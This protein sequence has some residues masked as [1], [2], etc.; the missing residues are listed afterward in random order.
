[1]K[2]IA[3][4]TEQ[5]LL[6]SALYEDESQF[7]AIYGRRRV[8]K[9]FLIRETYKGRFLFEHAG[10]A[11]G[12]KT[13]QL[14]S[15]AAS[16]RRSGLKNARIPDNWLDAFEMLKD[17][18]EQ[19]KSEKK[20]LFIDELS[21]MDT[22]KSGLITAIENFWNSWASGRNDVVFIICASATSW[23]MD[24]VIHNK[25]GLYNRLTLQIHLKPF[26]LYECEEYLKS[27]NII[28]NRYEIL[29]MYMIIG[30]I[31]FYWKMIKKGKSLAQNVDAMFFA[32]NAPLQDEFKY[33]YASLFK[34]P[35][36]YLSIVIAL[37]SKKAGMTRAELAKKTGIPD[38]GY[39]TKLTDELINCGFIRKYS[40][41]GKI[42]KD[43]VYQLID[44]YTLFYFHF[45]E[46]LPED[47]N[48]WMNHIDTPTRNAWCGVAFERV[49]MEHISQIKT[50]LG[51]KGVLSEVHA[52]SCSGN[53]LE[54]YNGAQ[55]DL[56]IVRKDQVINICEMKYSKDEYTFSGKDDESMRNKIRAFKIV[57]KTKY[58]IHP[59]LVTTY[60]LTGGMYSG[61]IQSVITADD[62]FAR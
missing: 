30:G 9:T 6:K 55:I 52:W 25:G 62:L 61:R 10:L 31:P 32:E 3:R 35:K 27:R 51:I 1:M 34:K 43:A 33:L 29:E 47:E 22:P 23:M 59:T 50:A 21:W 46:K 60:G 40:M 26:S 8:G 44:N 49:C 12:G 5:E 42:K 18:V 4:E 41:F 45:L 57:T 48:F 15:F 37:A 20:I 19:S 2:L 24:K 13:E 53:E 14:Q 11:D 39:L 17:L 56:L 54:G 7:I 36:N 38:S 16:L 58:S 28:L